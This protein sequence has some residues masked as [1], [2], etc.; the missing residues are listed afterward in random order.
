[1]KRRAPAALQV[2]AIKKTIPVLHASSQYQL[3]PMIAGVRVRAKAQGPAPQFVAKL[4]SAASAPAVRGCGTGP[5]APRPLRI[6]LDTIEDFF[7]ASHGR[8]VFYT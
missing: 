7:F 3:E 6:V 1:M 2:C 4:A 8:V 5:L